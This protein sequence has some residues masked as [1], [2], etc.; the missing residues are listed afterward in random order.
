MGLS[1]RKGPRGAHVAHS[2]RLHLHHNNRCI[3]KSFGIHAQVAHI[4]MYMYT[5]LSSSI[6][7]E[8]SLDHSPH[9]SLY[10]YIHIYVYL[11]EVATYIEL[12]GQ[13]LDVSVLRNLSLRFS[14]SST[15]PASP[16]SSSTSCHSLCRSIVHLR[17]P[18]QLRMRPAFS[19][20]F[21]QRASVFLVVL[22]ASVLVPGFPN[23][24]PHSKHMDDRQASQLFPTLQSV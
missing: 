7:I 20:A 6:P 19:R 3:T 18:H 8:L 9:L 1:P 22:P 4:Y 23:I 21:V 2:I 12:S 14:G 24:R 17:V 13:I 15:Q 16:E 5:H 11:S 10:V